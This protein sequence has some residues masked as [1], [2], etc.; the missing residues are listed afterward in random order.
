M[1]LKMLGAY[2]VIGILFRL[3]FSREIT[4][5]RDLTIYNVLTEPFTGGRF[6]ES[7]STTFSILGIVYYPFFSI[8]LLG[9]YCRISKN[10]KTKVD[11]TLTVLRLIKSNREISFSLTKNNKI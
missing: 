7:V 9:K 6:H 1:L 5:A 11:F 3:I 8:A 2:L 4:T 10:W